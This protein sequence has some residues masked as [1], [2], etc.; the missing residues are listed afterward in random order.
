[1]VYSFDRLITSATALL[2]CV[3]K[4]SRTTGLLDL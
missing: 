3:L 1:M 2:A 4:S